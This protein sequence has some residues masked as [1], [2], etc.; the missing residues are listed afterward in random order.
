MSVIELCN[1]FPD[2]IR[3][4]RPSQEGDWMLFDARI[5]QKSPLKRKKIL[6]HSEFKYNRKSLS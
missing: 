5:P 4:E 1:S 6:L 2:D 3:I